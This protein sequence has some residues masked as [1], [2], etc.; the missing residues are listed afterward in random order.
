MS[1]YPD[2]LRGMRRIRRIHLIGIGGSG[3]SGIA[4]VLLNLGYDI[5]GSDLQD[6]QTT[7]HLIQMGAT[8]KIGHSAENIKGADVIVT[9][10]AVKDDNP[11]VAQARLLRIPLVPRALM[12]G[13]LMRFRHGIAV[14]GTHGK[15]TTTSLLASI[16]AEAGFDPTFVIGGLLNSAGANAKLG[17]GK[18][19]V[20]EADESDASFL[21][22]QPMAA[23][24]TNIDYDHMGTYGGDF[25]KLRQTFVDFLHNLPFY[26][27]AVL[28]LDDPEVAAL[29]PRIH[30]PILSYGSS[31][32][33][34]FQLLD[35]EAL[36]M[37]TR[38]QVKMPNGI[39]SEFVV[40]LPGRHSVLNSLAAIAIAYDL[41]VP[42][43]AMRRAL[44]Q[45][46][47]VGRR[48]QAHPD[49][50]LENGGRASIMDDYGH[51]PTEIKAVLSAL[52]LAFP[53][54]RIVLAFQ[55][56]RYSRT[57]EL[58]DDFANVLS[59]LDQ[60][61]LT[62]V[63]AA[64]EKPILNADGRAL[65]RAI[66]ARGKNEPI[67]VEKAIDIKAAFKNIA[68]DGDL[69]IMMGAGDIG[70]AALNFHKQEV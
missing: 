16:L 7:R 52:Q 25:E 66:R 8:I 29:I 60:L 58:F 65:S 39:I 19:L 67:F 24:V 12:L 55:P 20:A 42:Q 45:F 10:T 43:P 6:S 31:D 37:Q 18:Y 40:N 28:C 22:L 2:S 14:A 70:G 32:Q 63:Y 64:G 53:E 15:T 61:I 62:E 51:H 3:M 57:L 59:N 21:H 9:S 23:I 17:L 41:G 4:E 56:H 5:T 13:E 44:Q 69:L 46:K 38:F 1:T 47:G 54:K 50:L 35:I 48:F 68:Q 34:D 11:E 36:G 30:R 49:M 27:L 26:G 33:C